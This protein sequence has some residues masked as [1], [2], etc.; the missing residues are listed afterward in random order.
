MSK[1]QPRPQKQAVLN[2]AAPLPDCG[3]GALQNADAC[4]TLYAI[5]SMIIA[6]TSRKS[7]RL[8]RDQYPG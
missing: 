7:V 4:N 8:F 5:A 6:Q 3:E 1:S 2:N